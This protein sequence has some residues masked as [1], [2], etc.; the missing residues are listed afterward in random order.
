MAPSRLATAMTWSAGTKRNVGFLSM[1]RVISHGQAMR[2]TRA[3]S[4][5]THFIGSLLPYFALTLLVWSSAAFNP[6]ASRTSSD[7]PFRA[8][9]SETVERGHRVGFGPQPHATGL[10]PRVTM[11]QVQ[12]A[13]EPRLHVVAH[14]HEANGVPLAERRRSEER[15]VGKECRSRWSPY[16]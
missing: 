12:L 5:V 9:N 2:S 14:G 1:N 10:E 16:H 15:R 13:V 3:F 11:I 4:R 6:W 8:T 7:A